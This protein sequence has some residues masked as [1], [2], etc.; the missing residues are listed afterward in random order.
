MSRLEVQAIGG[1]WG[2]V[3]RGVAEAVGAFCLSKDSDTH[4]HTPGRSAG[5]SNNCHGM[6]CTHVK[7]GAEGFS[8]IIIF[9]QPPVRQ[10]L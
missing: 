8:C 5:L 3:G 4:D 7:Y 1:L 9:K 2:G 10:G 6:F